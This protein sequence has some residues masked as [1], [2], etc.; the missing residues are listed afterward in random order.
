MLRDLFAVRNTLLFFAKLES[1]IVSVGLAI[2][3]KQLGAQ[4]RLSYL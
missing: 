4:P 2:A 3:G 1:G